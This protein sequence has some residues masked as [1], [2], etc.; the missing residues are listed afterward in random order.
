MYDAPHDARTLTIAWPDG[1]N[2]KV[3]HTR[4][5]ANCQCASC[6]NEYTGEPIL[7]KRSIPADIH[8]KGIEKVGNYAL[9]IE[10]SDGHASGFFPYTR[11]RELAA[12]ADGTVAT[13]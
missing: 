10:W 7:D 9:A 3:S 5:R 4:L 8:P 1:T 12:E 11:I 13:N 6:V 2:S